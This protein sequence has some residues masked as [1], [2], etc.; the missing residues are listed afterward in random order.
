MA[1]KKST[2]EAPAALS[3]EEARAFSDSLVMQRYATLARQR[4]DVMRQLTEVTAPSPEAT[5]PLQELERSLALLRVQATTLL[6]QDRPASEMS[7]ILAVARTATALVHSLRDIHTTSPGAAA[8]KGRKAA[9]RVLGRLDEVAGRYLR[10]RKLA[11]EI[12]G[13]HSDVID[14][15]KDCAAYLTARVRARVERLYIDSAGTPRDPTDEDLTGEARAF[16][17]EFVDTIDYGY[18]FAQLRRELP[19]AAATKRTAIAD[20]VYK[21]LRSADMLD[22]GTIDAVWR[23]ALRAAGHHSPRN[24]GEALRKRSRKV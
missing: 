3:E 1:T 12:E 6:S 2:P 5:D 8:Q 13:S 22:E 11:D 24:L 19:A 9:S 16:A 17:D 14:P 4:H 18:S 15:R 7:R 10:S 20:A 23:A 21:R